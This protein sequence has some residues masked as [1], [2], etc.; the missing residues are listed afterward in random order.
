MLIAR[1]VNV[2]PGSEWYHTPSFIT[3]GKWTVAMLIALYCEIV[4]P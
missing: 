3:S 2:V 4:P 1:Y